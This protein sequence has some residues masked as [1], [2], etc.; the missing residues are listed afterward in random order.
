M[1]TGSFSLY[2]VTRGIALARRQGE[3]RGRRRLAERLLRVINGGASL[4]DITK[5]LE[6]VRGEH[7]EPDTKH[8]LKSVMNDRA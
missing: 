4:R 3:S 1:A 8:P 6:Q 7:Q 2:H 5:Y